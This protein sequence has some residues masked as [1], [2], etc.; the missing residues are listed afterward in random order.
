MN[1]DGSV[2]ASARQTTL[3]WALPVLLLA[4]LLVRLAFVNNEG[5][6]TDV[7]TYSAWAI[8]LAQH[9]FASF[10]ST[11]GFAD[12]P[13]GYFY[14]LAVVGHLWQLFFAAHD[15]GYAALRTLV[16]L[17]AILADL[18]AGALLYAV[19]RR[20]AGFG[21]ALGAAALYVLNPATIYISALWGQVDSISGL[22]AL[23]AIYAL[24]RSADEPADAPAQTYWIVFAWLSFA[25]SLLIKPQAAVLLPL[26]VAFAFVDA[27]RRRARLVATALGAA[28]ALLLAL[29]LTEPFHPSNPLSA[30]AWLIERYAYGAN[31]YPYNSVNAF[32]LW[33]VRGTLWLPDSQYIFIL[34]QYLWGLVLVGAALALVTWRYVAERTPRAL[35]EGCAIATL[36]FFVLAT[37]MHERYLFNGVLFAIACIPFARRYLWG[38]VALS[39]VLFANL[40]YSLQYLNVVTNNVAGVNSQNLWGP[41]TSIL[42]G[43]AVAAFFWLG[44]QY[45]GTADAAGPARELPRERAQEAREQAPSWV[46]GVRDWF[47]PREGL[48]AMRGLDYA[49]A[50]ALGIGNFILSFIGYWW[51]AEKVFDEIYF[52]RA[53]E[54]YLQN[55]RIY[56][57]THPPLS[58]LLVALS[59]MLFGG[60]PAGHGLGGWTG[61]NAIVGHMSNGDNSYGWRFLDVVFGA[62]VVMLLYVFA[63]RITGSTLFSTIAALLLTFDGMHFVQSRIATPEGFVIFFATLAVYAFYRFWIS[64]QVGE[65]RHVTVPPWAFAAGAAAALL[66]GA[67]AGQICRAA[68]RFDAASSVIVMLYV[69]CVCYLVI[70]YVA[71]P[72]W[73]G[74]GRQELTY[75]EGS[76]ALRGAGGTV[77]FAADGGTVDERGKIQ[78]GAISQAKGGVLV[79]DD[80]PLR[81]EYRRDATVSYDTPE[82]RARYAGDEIRADAPASIQS[83]RSS[84]LWLVLFTVALGLLVSSKWYGVMGFG[85][86]FVILIWIAAS[87][88]YLRNK[89]RP[90]LWG[91]PRGFRLD[92]AL[93]TILVVSATVYL[94]AWVPDL[95]RQS[96]DPNEI[97]NANDLVY[98]Q[99]SMFDYHDTLKATHPYSSKWWEWPIDYVPIAYYYQDHRKD[100]ND[101]KGCC[102]YEITSMPNP[103]ILWFG[104]LCVPWVAVLAWR[105]RNKG[106]A[107]IVV[108]YLLQWLPWMRSPRITFAYHFYV[109]IPL[110]CLCNVV[111]LQRL[112][113]WSKRREGGGWMGAA[114]VGAYVAAAA[115][116]F[117]YFYPILAA[118][119]ISWSAWHQR[120]WFPTW[121]IG[122]G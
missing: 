114:G 117:V 3:A 111:V 120:M 60:M 105:E 80:D 74:D 79:Y 97:H 48:V 83:G 47:N 89:L 46:A 35:L 20:F 76:H 17:P 121:I 41:W 36:A 116:G 8:A 100:T 91:N 62:L 99:K 63:K 23:L 38:A 5:F 78:R 14:I 94:L 88:L 11:I 115:L 10:Y 18:C 52:A 19:V 40:A 82:G 42:S 68:W 12:Y 90:A 75:A 32:N 43:V 59:M 95:A 112:W 49:I 122:P 56:E 21:Y 29:A 72:K 2:R 6:K 30:F 81:I 106:Y 67:I 103:V 15:H 64:S 61:L 85:V 57:N 118:H 92:A 51:P 66:A 84:K 86:S 26:M 34:P 96:P 113:E 33:A 54:E 87:G 9:G 37:R 110:I 1:A 50:G 7:S 93:I 25:Y 102:V 107:L 108:T 58:K 77:L 39:A 65:R 70:R 71:F 13:P 4:G 55:L 101:P 28:A 53:G 104:L 45:L 69:G 31:V 98:R 119:P 109:D 73:L 24:L 27:P 16:K 22:F 44:Y